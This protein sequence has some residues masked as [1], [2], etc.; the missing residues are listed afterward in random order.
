MP[1]RPQP[2]V[3][4]L[5]GDELE[6]LDPGRDGVA[7]RE[8][9]V[10]GVDVVELPPRPLTVHEHGKALRHTPF[11]LTVRERL[12][13]VEER[14]RVQRRT[15]QENRTAGF[16]KSRQGR[17]PTVRLIRRMWGHHPPRLR[18][19]LD[20]GLPRMIGSRGPGPRPD[21]L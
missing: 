18:P 14:D 1:A 15:E 2:P 3:E 19:E 17:S 12:R 6:R 21:A 13:L 11:P 5:P 8:N 10:R 7:V 20:E 16:N 4:R 9:I